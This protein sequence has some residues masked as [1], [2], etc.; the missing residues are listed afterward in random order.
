MEPT[1]W[2]IISSDRDTYCLVA[3][4]KEIY[5]LRQGDSVC[6]QLS[7][8]L[9]R[10]YQIIVAMSVSYNHKY[11]ALYTNRGTVWMGTSDLKIKYCEFDTG[12]SER[13]RQIAWI[14]DA[15]T[16]KTAEA[17]AITYPSLLI[18]VSTSGDSNLYTYDSGIFL[19][20]EMD[21]IRVLTSNCHEM[22]QKVPHSVNNI[23]AINSQK[24][25]CWLFEAHKKF[26]IK[27]HKSDEYL[28]S[29]MNNLDEA[30]ADCISA[31]SFEYDTDTQKS[32]MSAA[33]FGKAFIEG[34]NPD[35]YVKTCRLLRVLNAVRD[36]KIGIPLTLKQ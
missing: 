17:I 21:G 31:A 35:E 5:K 30:V 9:E 33:Y 3:S 16:C 25:A 26:I 1:C 27:S 7:I 14:M 29:I 32:L 6:S 18:I 15:E 36:S 10:D 4:D 20:P 12:R 24:P 34:H 19:I 2:E 11:L 23:F 22:I 8:S 13:P 28:C